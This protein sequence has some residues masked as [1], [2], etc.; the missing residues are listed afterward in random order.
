MKMKPL[1]LLAAALLVVFGIGAAAVRMAAKPAAGEPAGMHAKA[2]ARARDFY[3]AY[4]L[5]QDYGAA[6]DMSLPGIHGNDLP[7]REKFVEFW[8]WRSKPS[9]EGAYDIK[10]FRR[11]ADYLYLISDSKAQWLIW[12]TE[13]P[14]GWKVRK[15][16]AY[17]GGEIPW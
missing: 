15:F 10:E 12:V 11:A 16:A 7:T 5:A 13:K 17:D 6:W 1:V 9:P 3:R 14:E 2:S 8:S 4:Y